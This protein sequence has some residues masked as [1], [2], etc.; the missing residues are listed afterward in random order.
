MPRFKLGLVAATVV[1]A[2][3]VA[4]PALAADSP[5]RLVGAPV[6]SM[7]PAVG[8][9]TVAVVFRTNRELD[10]RASG[11]LRGGVRLNGHPA[12][13]STLRSAG[14]R[15]YYVAY[16][17]DAQARPGRKAAVRVFVTQGDDPHYDR[18][19]TIHSAGRLTPGS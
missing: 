12:S 18:T 2:A 1:A 5:A 9:H 4:T 14:G 15:H 10:R 3:A 16:V 7:A 11:G 6:A 19:V 17:R 8:N 13:I